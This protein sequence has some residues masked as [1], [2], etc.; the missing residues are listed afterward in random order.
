M[1]QPGGGEVQLQHS[2][3]QSGGIA[4]QGDKHWAGSGQDSRPKP[5]RNMQNTEATT[6]A[7]NPSRRWREVSKPS[8]QSEVPPEVRGREGTGDTGALGPLSL[9][10]SW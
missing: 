1:G 8:S 10:A 4:I 3:R 7:L 5:Q 9:R 2:E 6:L